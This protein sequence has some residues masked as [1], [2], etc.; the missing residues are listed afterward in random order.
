MPD[1]DFFADCPGFAEATRRE[2][3][4]RSIPFLG[5]PEII[6]G[7]SVLPMT[8][9]HVL[10]LDLARSPFLSRAPAD[11]LCLKPG[12]ENDITAFLWAVSPL[13]LPGKSRAAT[14]R[15][16]RFDRLYSTIMK[17]PIDAAVQAILDYVEEAWMDAGSSDPNDRSY[18]SIAA[19][20]TASLSKNYGFA[21][22]CWENSLWRRL[23]RRLT[24]K[25]NP[26]DVPLKIAFQY[27]RIAR[28]WADA[29]Y[30]LENRLSDPCI[31]AWLRSKQPG[32]GAST[33]NPQP[34]TA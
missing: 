33:L 16:R 23:T 15:R 21:V 12:I 10:W 29:E 18:F 6:C 25:V 13:F 31:E 34:S 14:R 4:L 3:D 30:P 8:L 7:L 2:N 19:T 17:Q 26:L 27:T 20:V 5:Q 22:D 32:F 11:V 1:V 24:G 28:R 9:R